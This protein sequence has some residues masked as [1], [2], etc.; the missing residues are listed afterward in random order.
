MAHRPEPGHINISD[1]NTK[2]TVSGSK[3]VGHSTVDSA[4]HPSYVNQLS[5]SNP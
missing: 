4:F 1:W 5:T 3:P 2:S